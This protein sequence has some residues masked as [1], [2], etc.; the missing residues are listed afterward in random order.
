VQQSA[1]KLANDCA[2]DVMRDGAGPAK[3]S[4]GVE[5]LGVLAMLGVAF[6]VMRRRFA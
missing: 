6:A 3:E 4:P 1:Q 5:L 2:E